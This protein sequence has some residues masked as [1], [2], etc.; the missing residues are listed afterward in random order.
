MKNFDLQGFPEVAAGAVALMSLPK[1][2]RRVM[3]LLLSLS[4]SLVVV[5]VVVVETL[6]KDR[7]WTFLSET[8]A[9]VC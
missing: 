1:H 6:G 3:E 4:L 9:A 5:V 2:P 7:N 8:K